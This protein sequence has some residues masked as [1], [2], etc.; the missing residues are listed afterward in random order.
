MRWDRGKENVEAIA[1]Q[2]AYW[3]DPSLTDAQNQRRGSA[4]TG[5]SVQN[6]RAEYIWAYVRTHITNY[7]RK[8]LWRMEKE[9]HILDPGDA[10]D[11]FCLHVVFTTHIQCAL[12]TFR[13]SV[14]QCT[15]PRLSLFLSC[16]TA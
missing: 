11:L 6:C 14:R 4:L 5:R 12:D 10:R 13:D 3:W 8:L 9:M 16:S 2:W 7:F 1:A 15:I